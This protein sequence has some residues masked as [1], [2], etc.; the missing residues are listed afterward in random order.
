M[1]SVVALA[2]RGLLIAL[3]VWLFAGFLLRTCGALL[4]VGGLATAALTGSPGMAIAAI[5][6]ST[7]WL[8]GQWLYALRHHYYRS[9]LARR[10]FLEWLP[11]R[12]DATRRWGV[13]N[14]PPGCR[15]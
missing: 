5:L 7:A 12:F 9:P 14:V 2:A 10:V 11:T 6:G 1:S 4:A 3:A 8:A 13:P 15:R